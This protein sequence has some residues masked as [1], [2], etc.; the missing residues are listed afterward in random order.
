M[1]GHRGAQKMNL[2]YYKDFVNH[3]VK[4]PRI[5]EVKRFIFRAGLLLFWP[6]IISNDVSPKKQFLVYFFTFLSSNSTSRCG[7]YNVKTIEF[8]PMKT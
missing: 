2:F 6:F 4:V 5:N 3:K 1:G 8:L 7:P